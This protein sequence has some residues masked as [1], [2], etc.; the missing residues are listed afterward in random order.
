MKKR[1]N[2]SLLVVIGVALLSAILFGVFLLLTQRTKNENTFVNSRLNPNKVSAYLP[3]A[4]IQANIINQSN[5]TTVSLERGSSSLSFAVPISNAT[6]QNED[7]VLKYTADNNLIE[8]EYTLLK[9]GIKED[10]IL[11]QTPLTNTF[12][13]DLVLKNLYPAQ[14]DDNQFVF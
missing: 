10:I 12:E 5:K 4:G 1:D 11:N 2:F 3:D 7:T 14:T 6:T 8:L 9:N 13:S